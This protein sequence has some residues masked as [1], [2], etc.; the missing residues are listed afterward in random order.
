MRRGSPGRSRQ[1]IPITDDGQLDLDAS[2]RATERRGPSIVAV[3]HMSQRARA[4]STRWPRS[5]RAA[6]A[7]GALVVGRRG[8]GGAAH[9]RRR[10]GAG[11][12][13]FALSAHKMLG[14]TGVGV[15]WARPDLLE[16]MEPFLG[17]GE[18]I[19]EVHLDRATWDE[20]AAGSS[21]PARRT[22]PAWS[23]S[24]P[25]STTCAE[26]GMET[27]QRARD[28]ADRLRPGAPA[29]AGVLTVLRARRIPSS[30]PAWSPSSTTRRASARSQ[31]HP[32]SRTASPCAPGT[33]AP[34]R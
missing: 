31:H 4:P 29:R 17:G 23:A 11:R 10:R 16:D 21:R 12:D 13:A 26:L 9:A 2:S 30:G 7:V 6:H 3:T 8:P 28:D 27:L 19:R 25:P 1:L 24:A 22:S 33:T 20:R 15:L 5:P 14:P 32:R 18:M 34:S